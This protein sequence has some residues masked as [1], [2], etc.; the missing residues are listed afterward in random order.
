MWFPFFYTVQMGTIKN[1]LTTRACFCFTVMEFRK[2][3]N[4]FCT[5]EALLLCFIQKIIYV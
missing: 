4:I 3:K 2:Q 1:F 5:S